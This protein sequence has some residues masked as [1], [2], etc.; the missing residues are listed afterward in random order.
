MAN[1]D[2]AGCNSKGEYFELDATTGAGNQV[3]PIGVVNLSSLASDNSGTLFSAGGAFLGPQSLF[4][5]DTDTGKGTLVKS[6]AGTPLINALAISANGTFFAIQDG[7]SLPGGNTAPIADDLLKINPQT[8]S[9]TKVGSTNAFIEAM[10]IAP[11]GKMYG[12][13]NATNLHEIDTMT[14]AALGSVSLSNV[15]SGAPAI[16]ALCFGLDGTLYETEG[17]SLFTINIS[18]GK[19]TLLGTGNYS[20]LSGIAYLKVETLRIIR[21]TVNSDGTVFKGKGFTC[22]YQ[23]KTGLYVIKFSPVFPDVP[24]GSVTQVF[25]GQNKSLTYF[26]PGSTGGDTRDNAVIVWIKNDGMMLV[27]GDYQG[28]ADDRAFSFIVA[29]PK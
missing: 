17:N 8:G 20:A 26:G 11:N 28:N 16:K 29:G 12:W 14:G 2:I 4:T 3:G 5:L 7:L 27:T 10:A 18:N 6:I 13:D 23:N 21:G 25:N 15:N 22:Q 1:D 19:P 9:V 24:S